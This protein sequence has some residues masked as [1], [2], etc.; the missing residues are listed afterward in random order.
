MNMDQAEGDWKILRG[1]IRQR[2]GKLTDDHL[3]IVNGRMEMIAGRVQQAY[4]IS[5]DEAERQVQNW[6]RSDNA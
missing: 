2:W 5:R 4:G 1:K 3:D 6:K